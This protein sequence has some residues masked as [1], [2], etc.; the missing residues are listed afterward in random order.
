MKT[1]GQFNLHFFRE[2][3][4]KKRKTVA[5][6]IAKWW[7]NSRRH[8]FVKLTQNDGERSNLLSRRLRTESNYKE[9]KSALLLRDRPRG[10]IRKEILR[11][12]VGL[13]GKLRDAEK[14]DTK[15]CWKNSPRVLNRGICETRCLRHDVKSV[16]LLSRW[17]KFIVK[18]IS[19][20]LLLINFFYYYY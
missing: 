6:C 19:L 9:C 15:N 20:L 12:E 17:D 1:S 4:E 13:N 14:L 18:A 7:V 5:C 8:R 16:C 2:K 11:R 10:I 3:K